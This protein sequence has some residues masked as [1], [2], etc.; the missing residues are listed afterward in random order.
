M[1]LLRGHLELVD[2]QRAGRARRQRLV[3]PDEVLDARPV[4]ARLG[5][6]R[7]RGRDPARVD[8]PR[9]MAFLELEVVL[10]EALGSDVWCTSRPTRRA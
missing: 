2:G 4:L 6:R 7:G 10:V 5:R 8:V 9:R 1:N 3:M